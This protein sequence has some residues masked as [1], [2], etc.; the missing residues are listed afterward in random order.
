MLQQSITPA[1]EPVDLLLINGSNYPGHAVFPYAF[2]Q[3]SALAR[4]HGLSVKRLELLPFPHQRWQREIENAIHRF[5]PRMVGTHVRQADSQYLPQ[6]AR[7]PDNDELLRTYF[8]VEHTRRIL[9]IVREL[10]DAPTIVGGFGFT[11]QAPRLV[12]RLQPDFGVQGEPDSVFA[13]FERL[14]S[15]RSAAELSDVANLIVRD[16]DKYHFNARDF[17]SPLDAPEYN[18]E[19]FSELLAFYAAIGRSVS[20]GKFAEADVPVE[21]MRGCP[22]SCY[23]CTEPTVKGKRVRRRDLDAIMADVEFLG[24]RNVHSIFF[25]CSEINMSGM[26]FPLRLAERMLRYNETR[27]GREVHW[28]AYAMPRPGMSRED[29][30][31]M[32]RAGYLPGWNEFASFDDRNLKKCKMPY[33]TEHVVRYFNDVLELSADPEVYKGPQLLRFEMFLGNAFIDAAAI[34]E[35]LRV[36]DERGFASRHPHGGAISATRVYELNG[37][38]NCGTPETTFSVNPEGRQ[39]FDPTWPS[40]H[41]AP[42]LISALGSEEEVEAFLT[43]V[44]NTFLS[45]AYQSTRRA[46]LFLLG[47]TSLEGFARLLERCEAGFL[48]AAMMSSKLKPAGD[49]YGERQVATAHANAE[50]LWKHPSL[51]RLQRLFAPPPAEMAVSE[52]TLRQLLRVLFQLNQSGFEAVTRCLGLPSP[53]SAEYKRITPYRL[54]RVLYARFDSEEAV[55]ETAR[56]ECELAVGSLNEL[57]LKYLLYSHAVLIRP[58]YRPL[59]FGP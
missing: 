51:P 28:K 27:P 16:G 46:T 50:S 39:A 41:Y 43:F 32:M 38:A 48:C 12:E 56:R 13:S 29:M 3:V 37:K 42:E 5:R 36:V 25:V 21:I 7:T 20:I 11:A 52:L 57:Q 18:D 26:D 24:A 15:A 55:L 9:S 58:D 40:F 22:C 30:A 1:D 49:D 47:S 10:T 33:R 44:S 34:R 14:L 45:T 54:M 6:Y 23:F 59:L 19:V 17:A 35:T 2:I 4:H 31:V 53:A 8:P